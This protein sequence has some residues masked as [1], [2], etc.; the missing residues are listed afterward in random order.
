MATCGDADARA[1]AP[2]LQAILELI[3][4]WP[5][6]DSAIVMTGVTLWAVVGPVVAIVG[7]AIA[8]TGLRARGRRF[9]P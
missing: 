4:N 9:R 8:A 1:L 6:T 7:L 2:D 3:A 5:L